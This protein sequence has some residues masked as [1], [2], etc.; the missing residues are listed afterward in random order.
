VIPHYERRLC[1]KPGITGLA[2]LRRGYDRTLGDVKKKLKYD[3]LYAQKV[4]PLLDFKLLA[5]TVGAVVL[6]TG[7]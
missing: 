5:M 2:Q 6:R 7:R 1:V 3:I 4:C